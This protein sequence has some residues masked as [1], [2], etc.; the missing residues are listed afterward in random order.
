MNKWVFCHLIIVNRE[1]GLAKKLKRS[2]SKP[3]GIEDKISGILKGL[4]KQMSRH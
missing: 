2:T 1:L 4:T 3:G